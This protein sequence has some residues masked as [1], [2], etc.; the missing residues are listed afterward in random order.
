MGLGLESIERRDDGF[1]VSVEGGERIETGTV[2]F[3]TGVRPRLGLAEAAGLEIDGGVVTD[4]SMRT[5]GAGIFAVGDIASAYNGSARRHVSVEHWGDALEHGRIAG[6]VI[7]G[8]EATWDMVPGF[9]STIGDK[10]MK[11]WHWGDGWD[12]L[13]FQDRGDAFVVRYGRDGILVGVLAHGAD[14]EYEQ[15]R[16]P[17]ERGAAFPG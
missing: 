9:W 8:G 10:T 16:G 1:V 6:T 4:S 12:N 3:G 2:L 5:G 17:I 13:A 11:Y 15:G 14:E 7:A